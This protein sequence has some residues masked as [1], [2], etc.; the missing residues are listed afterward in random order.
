M[1]WAMEQ[2]QS[3]QEYFT[4]QGR[5]ERIEGQWPVVPFGASVEPIRSV[6]QSEAA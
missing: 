2:A 4:S 5:T 1:I 3:L 6:A